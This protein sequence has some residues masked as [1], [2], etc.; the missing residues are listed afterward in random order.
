MEGYV[1]ACP[2]QADVCQVAVRQ[3]EGR[4]L[5]DSHQRHVLPGVVQHLQKGRHGSDFRQVEV[6]F[7]P[8]EEHRHALLLQQL[9]HGGAHPRHL[10]QEDHHVPVLVGP[11]GTAVVEAGSKQLLDPADDHLYLRRDL[12][13]HAALRLLH[14]VNVHRRVVLR[15]AAGDQGFLVG[16]VQLGNAA[17]HQLAEDQ[18]RTLQHGGSAAEVLL[19]ENATL[20]GVGIVG[21]GQHA[22]EEQRGLRPAE[23]VDALLHVAHHEHAAVLPVDGLKDGVLH[24]GHVL[25]LVHEDV[26]VLLLQGLPVC[27]LGQHGHGHLL[28]VGEVQVAHGLLALAEAQMHLL[29]Q[30]CQPL[31]M[32]LN[33]AELTVQL[34]LVQ[35]EGG[36]AFLHHVLDFIPQSLVL[37]LPL[38]LP[39]GEAPASRC[40]H[41]AKSGQ[42]LPQ[43]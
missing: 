39:V 8:V 20:G 15:A 41:H 6:A 31:Q 38:L 13:G 34:F 27:R 12:P 7:R 4:L 3:V 9:R 16:V 2:A 17:V 29:H 21:V 18:V 1:P 22:V 40:P 14:Q 35:S 30:R 19:Q 26:V 25:A 36:G 32:L 10:R 43:G 33:H 23:A 37:L 28:Q 11:Q 24:G 42:S 5:Q